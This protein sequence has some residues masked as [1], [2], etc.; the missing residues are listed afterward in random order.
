MINKSSA[1]C[2]IFAR[3]YRIGWNP[4]TIM[5]SQ[6]HD[7]NK[8]FPNPIESSLR[9]HMNHFD[10]YAIFGRPIYTP[11]DHLRSIYKSGLNRYVPVANIMSPFYFIMIGNFIQTMR[12]FHH[13][14]RCRYHRKLRAD[15]HPCCSILKTPY[16][17]KE[18]G[19]F[20]TKLLFI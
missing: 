5:N 14:H 12:I 3:P 13:I 17:L 11:Y 19:I 2:M 15:I 6:G 20:K 8:A 10:P 4:I 16:S 9:L 7:C 1:L 18:Y